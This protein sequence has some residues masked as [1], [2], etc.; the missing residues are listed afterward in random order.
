[1]RLVTS[2]LVVGVTVV[3]LVW[4]CVGVD[5]DG[6]DVVTA[7]GAAAANVEAPGT[8]A[9]LNA[10]CIDG[11]VLSLSLLVF[12]VN[13][14]DDSVAATTWFALPSLCIV[15]DATNSFIVPI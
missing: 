5:D 15:S 3:E 13:D 8:D 14:S 6:D 2:V 12:S 10:P 11:T 1:M 4:I 7:A 9:R